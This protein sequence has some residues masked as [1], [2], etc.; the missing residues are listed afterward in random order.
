LKASIK[1]GNA[2]QRLAV[3]MTAVVVLGISPQ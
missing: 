1:Q 3:K 2:A